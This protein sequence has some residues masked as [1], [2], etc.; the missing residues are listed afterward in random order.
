MRRC[1]FCLEL[2]EG[3]KQKIFCSKKCAKRT[4]QK[5]NTLFV[6][7]YKKDKKCGICGFNKHTEILQFHHKKREKDNIWITNLTRT[8]SGIEAIKR[9]IEKCILL[10][11]NC[12]MWHHFKE[13][14]V[15]D[16]EEIQV[17][18]GGANSALKNLLNSPKPLLKGGKNVSKN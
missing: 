7:E 9:E 10:C 13:T 2:I 5:R 1:E 15:H 3:P 17:P 16:L 18:R 14:H 8:S 6:R 12:H 4:H 11:P